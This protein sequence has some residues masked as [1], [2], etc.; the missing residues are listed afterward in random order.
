MSFFNQ[1]DSRSTYR[2]GSMRRGAARHDQRAVFY[3]PCSTRCVK[4]ALFYVLRATRR[5]LHTVFY[6]TR[7]K[8]R[9]CFAARS[10]RRGLREEL[11]AP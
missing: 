9:S 8:R 3:A 7:S 1:I 2:S 5:D 11:D 6:T 4:R 10:K